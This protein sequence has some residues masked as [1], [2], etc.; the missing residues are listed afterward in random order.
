MEMIEEKEKVFFKP[1]DVVTVKQNISNKPNMIVVCKVSSYLRDQK[2]NYF[3]GIKCR[4]FSTNMEM[5]EGIFNTKDLLMV[6][7][8]ESNN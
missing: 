4:W 3:R 5:Q 6:E 8:A 7:P 2:S 1:G